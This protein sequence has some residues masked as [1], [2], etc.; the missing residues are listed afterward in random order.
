MSLV[1]MM[2]ALVAGSILVLLAS[3][4]LV[5]GNNGFASQGEAVSLDDGGRFAIEAIA[6]SVRQTAFVNWDVDGSTE[7][8]WSSA[9]ASVAGL[10]A[11]TLS[12]VSAGIDDA[13]SDVVNGSDV[14]ALRF[15]G[16]GPLP[17]GDGSVVN[18]AG[19]GVPASANE[20]ERGWSIFYVGKGEDGEAELRCKYRGA[21][22]WNA[23][24]IVR[25]VDSFQVLY[26]V[27]LDAIPDGVANAYV[28][29]TAINLL[30]EGLELE[31]STAQERDRD[32]NR[33]THWKRVTSIRI[34]I[35]LHGQRSTRMGEP[36]VNYDLFGMAYSAMHGMRDQGTR[37]SESL[38]P[39][40]L[41][42]RNR[43]L[44]TAT[45]VLRNPLL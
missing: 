6:R 22:S 44:Y 13:R 45:I 28:T 29:A 34:G 27:D 10:D 18:C 24:A 1:E 41:K 7:A 19:F 39:P 9:S 32:F 11:R 36:P 37:I 2:V 30:D 20:A 17:A 23:D 31:G 5:V 15:A 16:A 12:K 40:E 3:A 38:M 8:M 21:H 25:G 4:L 26:G 33:K 35:L 14:L 43:Q 42:A